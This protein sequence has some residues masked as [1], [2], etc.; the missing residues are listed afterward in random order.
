MRTLKLIFNL[1]N[2]KT[3]TLSL[4]DPKEGLTEAE[5]TAAADEIIAQK[6]F[7]VGEAAP[8]SVKKMFIQASSSEALA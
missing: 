1:N 7:L 6:A 8:E 5:V 4:A 3:M 2:K